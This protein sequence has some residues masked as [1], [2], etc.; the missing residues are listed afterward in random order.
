MRPCLKTTHA[1]KQHTHNERRKFNFT[2][3]SKYVDQ[4]TKEEGRKEGRE[5]GREGRKKR[6]RKKPGGMAVLAW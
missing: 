2:K 5:R 6:E 4:R 1:H 3:F